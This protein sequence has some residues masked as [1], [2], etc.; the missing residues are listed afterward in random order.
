MRA[1]TPS[2]SSEGAPPRAAPFNDRCDS[3]SISKRRTLTNSSASSRSRTIS[4]ASPASR[5]T[6]FSRARWTALSPAS[7]QTRRNPFSPPS[8]L[9]AA[10]P[11]ASAP[12]SVSK[13]ALQWRANPS[14]ARASICVRVTAP[15]RTASTVTSREVATPVGPSR[16]LKVCSCSH[17]F[18][19]PTAPVGT[20][21]CTRRSYATF[22]AAGRGMESVHSNR[23]ES[24][25][26]RRRGR[27][28]V[29]PISE[30]ATSAGV[31]AVSSMTRGSC[32]R[33]VA[34]GKVVR[35]VWC[36][37]PSEGVAEGDVDVDRPFGGSADVEAEQ[38]LAVVDA[39]SA[40]GPGV[41]VEQPA[42]VPLQLPDPAR[43]EEGGESKGDDALEQP[44]V[45]HP[46][47]QLGRGERLR[48][49][50]VAGLGKASHAALAADA[51]DG[52]DAAEPGK[53]E[54]R[55]VRGEDVA[56]D[57]RGEDDPAA[58]RHETEGPRRPS[59]VGV[60]GSDA[61]DRP[62]RRGLEQVSAGGDVLVIAPIE[63]DPEPVGELFAAA[64]SRR[65]F[66][67]EERAG[68]GIDRQPQIASE[69]GD[70]HARGPEGERKGEE[71]Q[72]ETTAI[73]EGM[74]SGNPR[75]VGE[76]TGGL[77]AEPVVWG[78]EL[79][80]ELGPEPETHPRAEKPG[81]V[82]PQI[83]ALYSRGAE[84]DLRSDRN[85]VRLDLP[86]PLR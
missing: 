39:Q 72:G 37:R 11:S 21:S 13:S 10:D 82:E 65:A 49:S 57:A 84:E 19:R 51:L 29:P 24:W 83:V 8:K 12:P 58:H 60:A 64:R 42:V 2:V 16:R 43:V 34:T 18:W 35:V 28:P 15:R 48:P 69:G 25:I 41:E 71:S 20:S 54:E 56:L 79:A 3:A 46:D 86:D 50:D 67:R 26:R 31:V 27:S 22:R 77:V 1:R 73:A 44:R 4:G 14:R 61:P 32:S 17:G 76:R 30:S 40:A 59:E 85:A 36:G 78:G 55:S 81:D 75:M 47:A 38:E 74:V 6:S 66:R 52:L 53:L 5:V 45:E 63:Q 68:V 80:V 9:F 70:A 33:R 62:A 23:E 7:S